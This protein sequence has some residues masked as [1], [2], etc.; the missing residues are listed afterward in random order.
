MGFG[1]IFLGYLTLLF[2][3]IL[4]IGILG[5]LLMYRGLTKLSGY[6]KYF[7]MAKNACLVFFIYFVIYGAFWLSAFTGMS[8][9]AQTTLFKNLDDIIYY[10]I[11]LVYSFLLYKALGGISRDVGFEK[12]VRREKSCTSCLYVFAGMT[13]LRIILTLCSFT[14]I[15]SYLTIALLFFELLWLA[16]TCVYLY[17]CYMMIATQEIIDDEDKKMREYDEKFSLRKRKK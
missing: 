8:D 15:A 9:I 13:V 11:L 16:Y 3:K 1:L 5:T 6:G 10:G 12:G 14:E 2:F 17:S 4:P 7:V